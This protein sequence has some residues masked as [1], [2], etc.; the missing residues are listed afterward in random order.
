MFNFLKNNLLLKILSYSFIATIVRFITGFVSLKLIAH[1]LGTE[2]MVFLGNFK[3]FN[4]SLK[5]FS[6]LGFDGGITK[7]V[8]EHK[9]NQTK[10]NHIISTSLISR[11][12]IAT[13]LTIV[14][15]ISFSLYFLTNLF[16]CP[17]VYS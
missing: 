5:T 7:L 16:N 3:D 17:S 11:L 13:I 9:N 1:F 15:D 2:G 14:S 12:C 6:S 4:S 8:S 10:I